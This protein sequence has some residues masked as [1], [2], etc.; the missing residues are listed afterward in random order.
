MDVAA[1]A[2]LVPGLALAL[3]RVPHRGL[4]GEVRATSA[5]SALE[6]HDFRA[7]QPGDDLRQ[8]DWNAVARTGELVLRIRQDEVAPRVEV[9][10]DGSRSMALSPRK[11]ACAREVALLTA[12]VAA[13]QGLAPTLLVA[14]AR[15]ERVQGPACRA[16]LEAAGFD[17]HDGLPESLGRLPPLRPCGVRVVVSDFLF[18]ADLPGLC[19]RLARGASALFLAQVLDAEDLDPSGGE[20]ARLVDSES[21]AALEELL[22][23]DVLAAY[24]RRFAE[25]QRALRGAALRARGALLVAPAED[26]LVSLV[27]GPLRPLFVAAG[28]S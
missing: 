6:L 10:L 25:H 16:V 3:P 23:E 7:Y 2:R 13:R 19:A 20:G 14:G 8:V 1:V 11:A 28:A 5:G 15:P 24:A 26:S 21:G 27:T 9:V 4:V 18:E 12:E 17:A 22:T